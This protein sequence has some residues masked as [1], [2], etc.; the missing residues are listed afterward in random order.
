ML[1]F[2]EYCSDKANNS[3]NKNFFRYGNKLISPLRFFVLKDFQLLV[4]AGTGRLYLLCFR[5]KEYGKITILFHIRFLKDQY[6]KRVRLNQ[7]SECKT[8]FGTLILLKKSL[9]M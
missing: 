9:Q 7:F 2:V 6:F 8:F 3:R 4:V 1:I 5:L